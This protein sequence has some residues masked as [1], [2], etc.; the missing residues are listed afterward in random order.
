MNRLNSIFKAKSSRVCWVYIPLILEKKAVRIGV[1]AYCITQGGGRSKNCSEVRRMFQAG[2]A[3]YTKE[4]A[5]KDVDCL[6]VTNLIR[7]NKCNQSGMLIH[8]A[9][10]TLATKPLKRSRNRKKVLI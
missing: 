7:E 9:L 5:T 10:F 3:V 8:K 1:L 2:P 4:I 6:K